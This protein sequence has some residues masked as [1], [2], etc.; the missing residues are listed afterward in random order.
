MCGG[1]GTRLD[2]AGEKPLFEVGGRPMVEHVLVALA[3][4]AVERVYAVVS[5]AT[6]GTR[7]HVDTPVIETPGDGYVADLQVAL[8]RVDPPV[9]TV[10]ADL[11]LLAGDA[12]DTVIEA[13]AGG[14]VTVAVPLAL[15]EALGLTVEGPDAGRGETAQRTG[16]EAVPAGVN[17]VAP[18]DAEDTFLTYDV[19]FAVNVNRLADAAVA[20]AFL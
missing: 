14:S 13:F 9:L 3:D 5:P 6:P 4:S 18:G 1:R 17:V 7:A 19:R 15:K 20:E 16:T 12:L 2:A 11:P 10:G 8:D